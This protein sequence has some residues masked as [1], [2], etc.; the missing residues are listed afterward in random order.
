M[1]RHLFNRTYNTSYLKQGCTHDALG[2]HSKPT[3][4]GTKLPPAQLYVKNLIPHTL[5]AVPL[6]LILGQ[7][8]RAGA[9]LQVCPCT[10]TL[11]I[12]KHLRVEQQTAWR[13]M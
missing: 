2:A 6:V 5:P 8:H 12:Q 10:K 4:M 13:E 7:P 1:A 11:V 3:N 9:S